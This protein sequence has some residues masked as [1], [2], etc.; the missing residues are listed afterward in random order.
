MI[1][2]ISQGKVGWLCLTGEVDRRVSYSIFSG[3][4]IP[5]IIKN[6]SFFERVIQKI[7]RCSFW[8]TQH[9]LSIECDF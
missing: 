5:N 4:N 3:F 6:G 9:S 1:F 7:K 2:W 8:G